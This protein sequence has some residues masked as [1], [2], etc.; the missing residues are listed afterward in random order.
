MYPMLIKVT[1]YDLYVR[2]NAIIITNESAVRS[3]FQL[4]YSMDFPPVYD[5][6]PV[7]AGFIRAESAGNIRL[8]VSGLDVTPQVGAMGGFKPT[9]FTDMSH[10]LVFHLPVN[11]QV[12]FQFCFVFT[13][14]TGYHY[15][16]VDGDHVFFQQFFI[17]SRVNTLITFVGDPFV[18]S[19]F[20]N[21]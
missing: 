21:C 4:G 10:S 15:I 3:T 12:L 20:V 14:I 13:K 16:T 18:K 9:V 17:S 11:P 6:L 5:H 2:V 8:S 7:D 19:L 1:I